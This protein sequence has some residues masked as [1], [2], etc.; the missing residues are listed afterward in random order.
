MSVEKNMELMQSLDDA[1]N[2]QDWET[3]NQRHTENTAVYW[4][5]QPEPTSGTTIE[6]KRSSS[7]RLFRTTTSII[8]RTRCSSVRRIGHVRLR[9]LRAR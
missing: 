1:W 2:N 9:G 5:G 4:P 7:S 8:D 3:F 6:P